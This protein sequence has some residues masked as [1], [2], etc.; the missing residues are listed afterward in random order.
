MRATFCV[1]G[2][3]LLACGGCLSAVRGTEPRGVAAK[4]AEF[5]ANPAEDSLWA[6]LIQC[7]DDIWVVED[8]V[9]LQQ[10]MMSSASNE[11]FLSI[12]DVELTKSEAI[13]ACL[14]AAI[15]SAI[16]PPG[17]RDVKVIAS[18]KESGKLYRCHFEELDSTAVNEA[19]ER[20]DAWLDGYY[21]CQH[22]SGRR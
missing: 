16:E 8:I 22:R 15:G 20:L 19:S 14:H 18:R 13:F 10:E 21:T 12:D 2:V 5:L 9:E 7:Y 3:L 17:S 6:L 11:S 1:V 4:H